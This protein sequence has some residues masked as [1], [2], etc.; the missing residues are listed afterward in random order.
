M[1]INKS[2]NN[3]NYDKKKSKSESENGGGY[4]Q[5]PHQSEEVLHVVRFQGS[6]P[7]RGNENL[8]KTGCQGEEKPCVRAMGDA[9]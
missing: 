3:S 2:L 4:E 9:S 6:D 5:V 8:F 1:Y 7:M